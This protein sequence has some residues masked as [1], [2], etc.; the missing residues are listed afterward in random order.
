[1]IRLSS[2]IQI[3][4]YIFN[5]V[6][7]C[8]IV[9]SWDT[10][11]DTA[12]L[13]FP[14]RLSW[15]KKIKDYIKKD[16]EIKIWLGYDGDLKLVFVGY[17]KKI[18]SSVPVEI[19]CEDV[20]YKLKRKSTTISYKDATLADVLSDIIPAYIPIAVQPDRVGLAAFRMSNM[21]PA[22]ILGKIKEKYFQKF[23]FRNGELYA[24]LAYWASTKKQH[25]FSFRGKDANI[26]DHDLEY[27]EADE[28]KI[29]LKAVSIDAQNN[30]T[31]YTYGDEEGEQRTVFYYDKSKADIDAVASE[32]IKRMKFTGYRGSFTTF[33]EPMVNHGDEVI[34]KD[35]DMPE[36][37]GSY[38]V[39]S[40]TRTYGMD[41]YRQDIEVGIKI[42]WAE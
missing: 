18:K 27:L 1:M 31:E 2:K 15:D 12:T 14:S 16:D 29:K 8:E 42:G 23:W 36:R 13:T 41:G 30:K 22:Q 3:G 28:V 37:D 9:S 26:I 20:A 19:E 38:L 32:E 10:L 21:T 34:L 17:V 7:S 5:A 35:I 33:G 39:K 6:E 11:T 24:G 25:K 4:T 40:V